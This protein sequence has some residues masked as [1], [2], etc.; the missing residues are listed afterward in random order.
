MKIAIIG[1]G[2]VGQATHLGLLKN[3]PTVLINDIR[4]KSSAIV[5][6]CDMVFVC[7]PTDNEGE[8]IQT[9]ELCKTLAKE[10]SQGEIVVRSTI[11]VK[12]IKLLE[13]ACAGRLVYCPEFLRERYWAQD[14]LVRP[15]LVASSLNDLRLFKL[16]P[17]EEFIR[18]SL[19]EAA[20]I[21]VMTNVFNGMRVVFANHLYDLC[22]ATGADF[23]QVIPFI[24]AQQQKSQSYLEVD[25]KL[26]GFGGKCLPKDLKFCIDDF[27]SQNLKQTLFTAIEEDNLSWPVTVRKDV[28]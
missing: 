13:D 8:I 16:V 18:M 22:Q 3:D 15:I 10:N 12:F 17:K 2:V 4:L 9:I 25:P 14:C 24:Q 5:Q 28:K 26:R 6:S 1:Y 19:E 27:S 7:V 20:I 21:K 23:E 11:P